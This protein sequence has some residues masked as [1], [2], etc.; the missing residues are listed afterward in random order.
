MLALFVPTIYALALFM[1]I[2]SMIAWGSWV[3]VHKLCG[4]WRVELLYW[5]YVWG[6]LLCALIAGVTFG[7]Q[8]RHN[9]WAGG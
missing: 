8:A 6:I 7:R 2:L 9:D 4:N 1:M 3:N 5:D